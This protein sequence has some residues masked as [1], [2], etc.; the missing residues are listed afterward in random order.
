MDGASQTPGRRAPLARAS[1]SL[2]AREH[3]SCP[4]LDGWDNLST[5]TPFARRQPGLLNFLWS[6]LAWRKSRGQS[7]C[8]RSSH[9][10]P[11]GCAAFPKQP[12]P[13]GPKLW[14]LHR[15]PSRGITLIRYLRQPGLGG[16]HYLP[17]MLCGVPHV[18]AAPPLPA[19]RGLQ[20]RG[21]GS[22]SSLLE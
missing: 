1:L 4:G 19:L 15:N 20:E 3:P 18:P 11:P 10:G 9:L 21:S 6:H 17:A 13:R 22:S 16:V 8:R 12:H 14:R 2:Q 5:H 7:R